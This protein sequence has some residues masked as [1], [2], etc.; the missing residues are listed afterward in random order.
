MRV[1]VGR[2]GVKCLNT[3]PQGGNEEGIIAKNAK[4][5]ERREKKQQQ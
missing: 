1:I 2:V 5:E 3:H 4:R